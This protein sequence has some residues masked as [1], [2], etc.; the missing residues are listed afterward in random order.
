MLFSFV[1]ILFSMLPSLLESGCWNDD[2]EFKSD[3]KIKELSPTKIRVGWNRDEIDR[4]DCI[5]YFYVHYWK[6]NFES[7]HNGTMIYRSKNTFKVDI[8]VEDDTKYSIQI[9]AFEDRGVLG[10]EDNWSNEIH[11]TTAKGMATVNYDI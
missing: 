4:L 10:G 2:P 7:R 6:T 9:N 1:F 8:D 5:D 11:I 3:P